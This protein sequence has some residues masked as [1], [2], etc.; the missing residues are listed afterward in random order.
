MEK[1]MRILELAAKGSLPEKIDSTSDLPIEVV[2]ELVDAGHLK[3]ID[4]SSLDGIAYIKPKITLAGREYLSELTSRKKGDHMQTD[5]L[6]IRLF[7]SHSSRDSALV[8]LLVAFLRAGLNLPASQIRCTSIDGYRLPVGVNTDEQLR[9]E[10]HAADVFVGIISSESL[11]SLYVAFELGARWG[12][13]SPID[14]SPFSWYGHK[15]SRW[16]TGRP[17]CI[18]R[19]QSSTIASTH[20]GLGGY[21]KHPTRSACRI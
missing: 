7:I 12:C 2:Q 20:Y 8:E 4:A 10:V 5:Q 21:L 18:E 1:H 13:W 11:K 15:N 9:R 17:K 16:P 14:P 19:G 6:A 3:A